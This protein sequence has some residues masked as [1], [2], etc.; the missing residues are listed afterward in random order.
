MRGPFGS[1]FAVVKVSS[2]ENE[3]KREIKKRKPRNITRVGCPAKFVIAWDQNTRQW[4]VKDFIYEHN[5]PMA[6]RDLACLL[7]LHR[8]ISDEQKANIVAMQ[9][10]GIR[11]HQIIDIMEMQY[12][13]YDKVGFTT[14]DLYN[15]C[16]RNKVETVAASDAQTVISYL[17]ECRRR[18]PDFFF[19]YKTDGKGHL[20]GLLWC[21]S[22]CRLD[23]A[24]FGDVIVFDSTYKTNR[25]NLPL[26][27][28]VGVNHHGSTVLFACGIISQETIESYVWI[29]STFSD[30]MVQKHPVSVLLVHSDDT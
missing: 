22:Q 10:S 29:L 2:E 23:Y 3:L 24:A 21:D 12:D 20:K 7:R 15:F 8:R 18:D 30:A 13:G 19:N 4:Y 16:Y 5:H 9:I 27:P 14:R 6:E 11:K 26:V 25:Y 1:L 17:I 28:F